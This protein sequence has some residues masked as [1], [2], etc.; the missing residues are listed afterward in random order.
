MMLESRW[1]VEPSQ[2]QKL[3]ALGKRKAA[4]RAKAEHVTDDGRCRAQ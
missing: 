1:M 4:L 2:L 3:V